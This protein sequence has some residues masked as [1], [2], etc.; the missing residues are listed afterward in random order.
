MHCTWIPCTS[1][2]YFV[3]PENPF[4]SYA[5]PVQTLY[6]LLPTRVGRRVPSPLC[7]SYKAAK[8]GGPSNEATC[9]NRLSPLAQSSRP[10]AQ[11]KDPIGIPYAA[12][13]PFYMNGIFSWDV[14]HCLVNQSITPVQSERNSLIYTYQ[15]V[16]DELGFV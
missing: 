1:I 5:T 13:R 6:Y 4:A 2:M 16:L 12:W 15:Q 3:T 14:K 10:E 8:W 9:H 11:S 7:L